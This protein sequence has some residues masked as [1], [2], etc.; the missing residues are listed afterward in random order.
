MDKTKVTYENY[1]PYY[2]ETSRHLEKGTQEIMFKPWNHFDV[3]EVWAVSS[4]LLK[5]VKI[6]Y[7]FYGDISYNDKY[8]TKSESVGTDLSCNVPSD[9]V[10]ITI[11]SY[12]EAVKRAK[13]IDW[14]KVKIER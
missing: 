1:K 2:K 14:S 4:H 5:N 9:G 13:E 12:E 7:M 3:I 6:G 8:L 10:K 11:L